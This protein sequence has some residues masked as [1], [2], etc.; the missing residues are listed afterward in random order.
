M[1][2][3]VGKLRVILTANAGRFQK[4][5]KRARR[6]LAKVSKSAARMSLKIGGIGMA[7][8]GLVAGG[9]FA[10]LIKEAF[11]TNDALAKTADK[12]GIA[13]EALAGMRLAAGLSGVDI[14][15]MQM[16]IQRM[17]RRVSEAAHDTGEAKDALKELG[18]NAKRLNQLAP[19]RMFRQVALAMQDVKNQGDRVRLAFKLFDSEGVDLVNTLALVAKEGDAIDAYTRRFGTAISRIDAAKLEAV[20]DSFR[21]LR[22]R[23]HGAA[24][25]IAVNLAPELARIADALLD[26]GNGSQTM[27]QQVGKAYSTISKWT[28]GI[29]AGVEMVWKTAW[30]EIRLAFEGMLTNMALSFG[31]FLKKANYNLYNKLDIEG[32]ITSQI[33]LV[34]IIEARIAAR[35]EG[36]AIKYE[37]IIS[38][39]GD[40]RYKFE[41]A[42]RERAAEGAGR[43]PGNLAA[44]LAGLGGSGSTI[45]GRRAKEGLIGAGQVL[46]VQ[47]FTAQQ[48]A[49]QST[50]KNT[51]DTAD[52]MKVLHNLMLRALAT[53]QMA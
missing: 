13:T 27:A 11:R 16:G 1:G 3:T 34:K 14:R 21:L 31:S 52:A 35:T 12:L 2:T 51:K 15:K 8:G 29:A 37:D 32:Y 44:L 41:K 17:T 36:V 45:Q 4:K 24:A 42:A 48:H 40:F 47:R 43:G 19:D 9:G 38:K 50:A 25:Q 46:G 18:L 39:L 7:I 49:I 53:V 20:N 28:V 26:I 10:Y 30:L 6:T 5:M 33:A 23:V 22:E